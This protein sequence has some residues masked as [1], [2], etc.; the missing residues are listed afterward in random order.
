VWLEGVHICGI[1]LGEEFKDVIDSRFV[2]LDYLK[3]E[4]CEVNFQEI[5]PSSLRSLIMDY[6]NFENDVLI[7]TTL[8]LASLHLSENFAWT[9]SLNA[10]VSLEKAS[11]HLEVDEDS[12]E[13]DQLKLPGNLINVT[14][15]ELS[16]FNKAVVVF[17]FHSVTHWYICLSLSSIKSDL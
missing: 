10:M 5:V 8:G 12:E 11:I 14:I 7:I 13:Y 2:H 1:E 15:L 6:N 9:L 17:V 4:D 16:G 3:L